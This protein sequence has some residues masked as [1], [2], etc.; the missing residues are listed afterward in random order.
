M[1]AITKVTKADI[2]RIISIHKDCISKT[3]S[4]LYPPPLKGW[5]IVTPRHAVLFLHTEEGWFA[6]DNNRFI[7]QGENFLDLYR[8][9]PEILEMYELLFQDEILLGDLKGT[10]KKVG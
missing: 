1:T 4:M 10:F 7:M 8:H 9:F 2:P 3:N 6:L 5:I